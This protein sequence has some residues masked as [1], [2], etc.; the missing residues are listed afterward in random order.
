MTGPCAA[1]IAVGSELLT[2]ERIDT[3]SLYITGRLNTLGIAVVAKAIVGDSHE[4][5][6]TAMNAA[7]SRADVVIVTGG[8]G[9]TD[10]DLTRE[11]AAEVLGVAQDEDP[12][13][14]DQI[15]ARFASRGLQMPEINRRQAMVPR[16]A[17]VL[18]NPRGTAPGLWLV[19]GLRRML[20][21]PGPPPEMQPML[22]DWCERHGRDLGGGTLLVRRVLKVATLGESHVEERA[23]PAYAR[24]RERGLPVS[25]TILAAPGQVELHLTASTTN[26][27]EGAAALDEAVADLA[28]ALG[29]NLFTTT[30]Q[31]L[32]EVTGEMLRARRRT[33][34]CAESCTGGLLM[35]RLTDVPG[36]SE[37]VFGGIVAYSDD[38][39]VQSLGVSAQLLEAYGAVSEPVGTA[40]ADGVRERFKVDIGV[41][42]TGIAGP[43]GGTPTKPVG[44]VVIA[45]S[46]EPE[47]S[48]RTYQFRG[49]RQ[50]IRL[51]ATQVALDRVRRML[52]K[53]RT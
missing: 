45:L 49:N 21:L 10:D 42:I 34:A 50:T 53:H 18:A 48:V 51:W 9:P 22:E 32:E 43:G 11:C 19:D 30:G 1:L 40:M 27:L 6:V 23:Q 52:L 20:L 2:P 36:S 37:Y 31:S 8:L 39:K 41:G 24:W 35:S 15:R 14:T 3:N 16:G 13:I 17:E 47:A 29:E 12:A 44:T 25:P 33:I 28:T 5:I 46:A 26:A 7:L 38:V 4:D